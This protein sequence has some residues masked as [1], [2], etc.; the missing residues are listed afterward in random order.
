LRWKDGA[1]GFPGF[2]SL[3]FANGAIFM[4]PATEDANMQSNVAMLKTSRRAGKRACVG[5]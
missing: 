1:S 5:G 4:T 3:E 2:L